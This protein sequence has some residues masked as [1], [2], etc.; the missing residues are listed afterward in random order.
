MTSRWRGGFP[1]PA[2]SLCFSACLPPSRS[3]SNLYL[4]SSNSPH[5]PSLYFLQCMGLP[6]YWLRWVQM[7]WDS[8]EATNTGVLLFFLSVSAFFPSLCLFLTYCIEWQWIARCLLCR[9]WMSAVPAMDVCLALCLTLGIGCV[10]VFLSIFPSVC[11]SYQPQSLS[12]IQY[13]CLFTRP[14]F[15]LS[16]C[17]TLRYRPGRCRGDITLL[18]CSSAP[19]GVNPDPSPAHCVN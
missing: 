13:S 6:Q 4:L 18:S 14:S 16:L 1:T 5:P 17:Q 9:Q 15:S 3:L 8:P 11:L 19:P 7:E 10:P 2:L 12:V